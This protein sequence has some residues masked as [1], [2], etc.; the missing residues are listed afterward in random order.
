[1][2]FDTQLYRFIRNSPNSHL[3]AAEL[4]N[5]KINPEEIHRHLLGHHTIN[6]ISFLSKVLGSIEYYH[7][8]QLAILNFT[9][10]DMD[11][12]RLDSDE[13]RDIIDMIMNI[14]TIEAA[15]ILRE[16]RQNEYKISLR[17][18]GV[19]ELLELAEKLG[20]GGHRF[21]AGAYVK[22][23]YEPLRSKIVTDLIFQL[24]K[25]FK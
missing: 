2:T 3:I 18:K 19:V 1:I 16:D 24:K 12:H 6:K 15:A 7:H 21:A 13:S 14:E 22:E 11:A 23:A 9:K 25:N 20:G 10:K 4:L 5:Y 17:S 8:G